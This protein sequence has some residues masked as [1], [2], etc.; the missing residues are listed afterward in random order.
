MTMTLS[1]GTS[2]TYPSP[3]ITYT[4]VYLLLSLVLIW[5]SVRAVKRV[6]R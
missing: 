4:F 1:N 2:V 3:W 6:D 5:L